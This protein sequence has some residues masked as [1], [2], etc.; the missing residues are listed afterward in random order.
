MTE[1]ASDTG[2]STGSRSRPRTDEARRRAVSGSSSAVRRSGSRLRP[3][4]GKSG[5]ARAFRLLRG[6]SSSVPAARSVNR[7]VRPDGQRIVT[8]RADRPVRGRSRA[9]DRGTSRCS[10]RL[11]AGARWSGRRSRPRRGRRSASRL[12]AFPPGAGESSDG[13]SRGVVAQQGGRAV[14]VIDDDVDVA[15]VVEVADTRLPVPT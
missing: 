4:A 14:L 13:A 1:F 7:S 3:S 9:E 11:C 5:Q 12:L 8:R 15:V 2:S 10:R 6:P